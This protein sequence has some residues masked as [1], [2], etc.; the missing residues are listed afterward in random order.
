MLSSTCLQ[1]WQFVEDTR[2]TVLGS[3]VPCCAVSDNPFCLTFPNPPVV[4]QRKTSVPG[5][6]SQK[7]ALAWAP[8]L[9][10]PTLSLQ[11]HCS[12]FSTLLPVL[13]ADLQG[14]PWQPS[15]PSVLDWVWPGKRG[16]LSA[17]HTPRCSA[18][19][20]DRRC[21]GPPEPIQSLPYLPS[22]P[23]RF[24]PVKRQERGLSCFTVQSVPSQDLEW[25]HPLVCPVL[26]NTLCLPGSFISWLFSSFPET[27]H[28][29]KA[30]LI[31]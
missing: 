19:L 6:T 17:D 26:R 10:L 2:S 9:E 28:W 3:A 13:E 23:D 24:W 14:Q 25:Y 20:H 12:P 8:V 30:S 15:L 5:W 4:L 29:L 22:V 1:R 27:Q 16:P 18:E 31:P 21:P 11:I 7:E